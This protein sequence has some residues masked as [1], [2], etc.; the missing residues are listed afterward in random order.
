MN[1]T[2]VIAH[3]WTYYV[4]EWLAKG[5]CA[6]KML[7]D[8]SLIEVVLLITM[9][10]SAF[11]LPNSKIIKLECNAFVNLISGKEWYIVVVFSCYTYIMTKVSIFVETLLNSFSGFFCLLT[12]IAHFSFRILEFFSLIFRNLF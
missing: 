5:K 2:E 8:C 6:F 9:Y 1:C 10:K 12:S 7:V 11:P 4:E 3:L